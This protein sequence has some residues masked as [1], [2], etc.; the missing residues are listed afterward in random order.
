MSDSAA[1]LA[2]VEKLEKSEAGSRELD[3]EIWIALN[4]DWAD[5]KSDRPGDF[6]HPQYGKAYCPEYSTSLDEALRLVPSGHSVRMAQNT[7]YGC[8]AGVSA[9]PGGSPSPL[10]KGKTLALALCIA[11]LRA[12]ASQ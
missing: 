2:L 7:P 5:W 6:N 3:A 4:P 1:L 8:N 9:E 10:S 12:R 11:A